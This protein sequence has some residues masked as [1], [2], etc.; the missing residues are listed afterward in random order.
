VGQAG[1]PGRVELESAVQGRNHVR[2][3]VARAVHVVLVQLGRFEAVPDLSQ[4]NFVLIITHGRLIC[5][6]SIYKSITET[7]FSIDVHSEKRNI[8]FWIL[9]YS[10]YIFIELTIL[11]FSL[12]ERDFAAFTPEKDRGVPEYF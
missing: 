5:H 7:L 4:N 11:F 2:G 10:I 9:P 1:V 6:C 8:F 3:A 12:T